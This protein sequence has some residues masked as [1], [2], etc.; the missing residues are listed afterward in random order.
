MQHSDLYHHEV[1]QKLHKHVSLP[2]A[3]AI[4][5]PLHGFSGLNNYYDKIASYWAGADA[6]IRSEYSQI[7]AGQYVV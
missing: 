7:R 2:V 4:H 3:I 6:K 5:G 1:Q